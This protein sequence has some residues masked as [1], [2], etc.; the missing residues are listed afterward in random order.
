MEKT[1]LHR[2]LVLVPKVVKF[3][4]IGYIC[5]TMILAQLYVA[6]TYR[7]DVGYTMKR[8]FMY[9]DLHV[10]HYGKL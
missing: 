2:D 1:R 9:G 10:D 8:R 6:C 7:Q 5:K 3:T 4:I